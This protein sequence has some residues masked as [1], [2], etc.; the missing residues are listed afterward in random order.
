MFKE[1]RNLVTV[2][3]VV[4]LIVATSGMAQTG[5]EE[6][7][8]GN[9]FDL[10]TWQFRSYPELT[11]TYGATIQDGPD[12][13]DYLAL[14][15][16]SS[17]AV[18]GSQFGV[19]LGTNETFTDVRIGAVVNVTGTA[20]NYHGL[21]ARVNY[22]IDD[23][24][25]SGYPGIIA[26][27]YIMLVHW[28]DGPTRLRIEVFKIVNN[29]EDIMQTY[30]EEPV[31]GIGHARSY[32]AELDVVG[33]DPVYIT[34][35][36]YEYKG[37]PLLGRTP[38]FIDTNGND[39]W[40]NEGF[41]DAV[42]ANGQ[43][44]IFGMNQNNEP[45]GYACTFDDVFSTSDGPAA[46]NPSPV[47]GATGMS[48]DVT[49][50]WIEA[51]FATSRELW[52]GKPGALEKVDPA[53]TGTT[54]TTGTLEFGQTYEW[55]IDQIGPSGTVTGHT[56]SFTTAECMSV[57]DFESYANTAGI[58]AAWIDN[59]ATVD[60][61]SLATG[62]NQSMQF[63]YQNQFD[64]FITE[65]TRTFI[66]TQDWTANNVKA[67]SLLF[68]GENDNVEQPIYVKLEDAAGHSWKVEHP[69][70]HAVESEQWNEWTVALEQF[71]DNAVDLSH[72]KKI[73]LGFGSGTN[74]GQVD[75]DSDIVFIDEISLCPARC[76]NVGM[77]D[78]S[79]DVNGD[80]RIDFKDIAI[81]A[82]G[83]L[84]DGLSATP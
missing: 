61:I 12:D 81:M 82:D 69:L 4:G 59:I 39:P 42:F 23:G 75:L 70:T 27:S 7:F 68:F 48:T 46:V 72:I 78:L 67:L 10:P 50:S 60:Y 33:S 80:C 26:S 77:V 66:S 14:G 54:Y 22:F 13:N 40:E 76:F 51:E 73:T 11:G 31:P 84:Q 44:A 38:T 53:P 5:W 24:S 43:S 36:L 37:G 52:I 63:E 16:T 9:A 18:G 2:C 21:S 64:P 20:R 83:W 6:T 65:A 32:Y 74:S 45:P 41:H 28:Q 71:S 29:L 8:G 34:G 58:M 15:E 79:G 55:R 49:L 3:A 30:H 56:W 1:L 57:E 35:S 17:A 25:I 62:D 19:G 47:I